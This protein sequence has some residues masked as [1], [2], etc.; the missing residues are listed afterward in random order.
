LILQRADSQYAPDVCE[1][2]QFVERRA[3]QRACPEREER[4][5]WRIAHQQLFSVAI[6]DLERFKQVNDTYGHPAGDNLLQ[7][8]P[9]GIP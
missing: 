5:E 4:I 9:C 8:I 6:L 1:I 7:Q 2:K 3:S